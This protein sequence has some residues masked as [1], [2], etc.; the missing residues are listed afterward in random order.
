[1]ADKEILTKNGISP[2]YI[3]ENNLK[4][5]KKLNIGSKIKKSSII[6]I[7]EFIKNHNCNNI[8]VININ[9]SKDKNCIIVDKILEIL[10]NN[11]INA[12]ITSNSQ[13]I[14]ELLLEKDTNAKIGIYVLDNSKWRYSFDFY[15]VPK[16]NI[17]IDEMER[18]ILNGQKIF[19]D[20]INSKKDF[21][22]LKNNIPNLINKCLIISR[23]PTLIKDQ[24]L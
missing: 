22:E 10:H 11:T 5:I 3:N 4:D 17:N 7:E 6:T 21:I 15:I 8:V 19:I 23:I 14:I 9:D 24:I 13:D 1:M 12:F 16:E 20:E 2:Q 18:K